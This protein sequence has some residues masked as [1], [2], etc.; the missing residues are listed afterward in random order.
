M[1]FSRRDPLIGTRQELIEDR[2]AVA[3]RPCCSSSNKFQGRWLNFHLLGERDRR[4]PVDDLRE[5]NRAEIE[6]LA[7]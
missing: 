3:H 7:A 4:E 2:L 1:Y 6:T 5:S